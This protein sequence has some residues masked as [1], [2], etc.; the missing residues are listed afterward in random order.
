MITKQ[1][2]GIKWQH[3]QIS[4]LTASQRAKPA[5]NG[6]VGGN[7]SQC[8]WTHCCFGLIRRDKW[9]VNR[10]PSLS[11]LKSP[12][13]SMGHTL[14]RLCV[15][16]GASLPALQQDTGYSYSHHVTANSNK[17]T[18]KLMQLTP[19]SRGKW[20]MMREAGTGLCDR[21]VWGKAWQERVGVCPSESAAQRTLPESRSEQPAW[22]INCRD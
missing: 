15:Y 18:P 16:W 11:L 8:E 19:C 1:E 10:F 4:Y 6:R 14:V 2:V 3:Q 20:R 17:A 7:M 5:L 13:E 21:W 22:L 9:G 12:L